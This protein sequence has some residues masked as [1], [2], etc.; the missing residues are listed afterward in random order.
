MDSNIEAFILVVVFRVSS[1]NVVR[2][3][4]VSL[5]SI[6]FTRVYPSPFLFCVYVHLLVFF[7]DEPTQCCA[8]CR[9][10][11]RAVNNVSSHVFEHHVIWNNTYVRSDLITCAANDLD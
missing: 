2:D 11:I 6:W 7:R 3:F 8:L 4:S 5:I 9:S 1:K 10:Y